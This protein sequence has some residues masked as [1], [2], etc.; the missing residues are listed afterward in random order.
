MLIFTATFGFENLATLGPA[1]NMVTYF[2]GLLHFGVADASNTLTNFMGT[3]YIL[4]IV[5][6]VF[7]D[8]FVGRFKITV[9][10]ACLEILVYILHPF[11]I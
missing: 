5:M 6:A 2:I 7:A 9:A 10:G 11:H 1:V 3:S 4:S 8:T